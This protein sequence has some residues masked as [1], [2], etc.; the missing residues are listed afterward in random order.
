MKAYKA[1]DWNDNATYGQSYKFEPGKTYEEKR[2]KTAETGFHCASDPFDCLNYYNWNNE[3][4]FYIVEA[5]GDID[6]DD[7]DSRIACTRIT[8][9][10]KPMTIKEYLL[11]EVAYILKHPKVNLQNVNGNKVRRYVNEKVV[12]NNLENGVIVVVGKD[13]LVSTGRGTI[14]CFIVR[15]NRKI[16]YIGC[17]KVDGKKYQPQTFYGYRDTD[18]KGVEA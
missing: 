6:E 12:S 17:F 1:V 15:D 8:F 13:T 14:V 5:E 10:E 16:R 9:S 11:E 3:N 18:Y 2:S 4:K 7:R